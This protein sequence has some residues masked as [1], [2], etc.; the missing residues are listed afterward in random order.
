MLA[1]GVMQRGVG[2]LSVTA[3][4]RLLD[5]SG[6]GGFAFT[7]S[8]SQTGYGLARLG[9]DVGLQVNVA[10]LNIDEQK[11]KAEALLGEGLT[12]F[13]LIAVGG[14]AA[15]CLLAKP[16]AGYVFN[17]PDLAPLVY[18]SAVLFATQVVTQFC[19]TA[20]AGVSAF[21]PYARQTGIG[22]VLT[23]FGAVGGGAFYGV[24]GAVWGLA[25]ASAFAAGLMVWRLN[26]ELRAHGL[27]LAPRGLSD[28]TRAILAV[29]FP[30]YASGF[31]LIPADFLCSGYLSS[32]AGVAALG[33]L[34]VTQSL[35]S[36][37]TLIPNALFGPLITH[38]ANRLE[39]SGSPDA[40]LNQLRAVWSLALIVVAG[41]GGLW[42][43]LVDLLFGGSFSGA[44][45]VGV[46]ALLA[47]IPSL[48]QSVLTSALLA[49]RRTLPL[50][51]IGLLQALSV[52]VTA[53]AL[54]G[55]Y[56]LAGFLVVQAIS[57][58][59]GAVVSAALLARQFPGDFLRSWMAPLLALSLALMALLLADVVYAPPTL[60]RLALAVVVGIVVVVVIGKY[61]LSADER[62][63]IG[64]EAVSV[65]RKVGVRFAPSRAKG[66]GE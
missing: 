60:V 15:L 47:F 19:Y 46:L 6:L 2:V 11:A 59:I 66:A 41:L 4:A 38:L 10:H 36:V 9:A 5:A 28:A 26:R 40:A 32:M 16:I 17:L 55:G 25:G 13:A 56:G 7:Q 48:A 8:V 22:S 18:A 43:L 58:T 21:A 14:S 62:V 50:V 20:F 51:L 61:A 23:L 49:L 24:S 45:T 12:L 44:R 57:M 53:R 34:R 65:A 35:M 52:A 39:R 64:Q 42:P 27:H 54:I 31:L 33:D 29:G 37:A 3:L 1:L 63:R 30:F